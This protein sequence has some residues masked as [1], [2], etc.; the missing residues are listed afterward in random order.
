MEIK[1][2]T[3]WSHSEKSERKLGKG[4][5]TTAPKKYKGGGKARGETTERRR[6]CNGTLEQHR[7][8][9]DSTEAQKETL[10]TKS[11]IPQDKT[12]RGRLGE[13]LREEPQASVDFLTKNAVAPSQNLN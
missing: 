4:E 10:A 5:R 9:E 3:T 11:E 1:G 8:T 13:H 7:A 2:R 6:G 12:L